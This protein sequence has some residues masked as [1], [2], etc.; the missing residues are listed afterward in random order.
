[1]KFTEEDY[2]EKW[3]SKYPELIES[4]GVIKI[5]DY[6]KVSDGVKLK[7]GKGHS[8]LRSELPQSQGRM[9]L[10][11]YYRTI[12]NQHLVDRHQDYPEF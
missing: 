6:L 7:D 10:K 11:E 12:E 8:V 5:E 3:F 1:M 2:N 9:T 4:E